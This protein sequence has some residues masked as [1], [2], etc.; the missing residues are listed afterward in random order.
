MKK[1]F[2]FILLITCNA[3]A[4]PDGPP[5]N[6][7][8]VLKELH[9]IKGTR[10]TSLK[11]QLYQIYQTVN[12]A[13][14][15]GSEA[16]DLYLQAEF[17]TQF[18]GESRDK[19]Q[20]I[21][22]KKKQSDKLKSKSFKESLRLYLSYLALTLENSMG[23]KI[24]NLIPSLLNYTTQVSSEIEFLDD[25]NELMK[26]PLDKS[27]IVSYLGVTLTPQANWVN[28]PG[29]LDDI[30]QKVILPEFRLKE[31]PLAIE[32]WNSQIER[33]SEASQY[34]KRLFQADQFATIRK[35]TLFWN[36]A[37]E[38]YLIGQKNRGIT[39]MLAVIKAY[40]THPDASA[41][42]AKLEEYIASIPKVVPTPSL[43]PSPTT[44]P[45]P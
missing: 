10:E 21:D 23:T 9:K 41:W 5:V 3:F 16:M 32:Y 17:S 8:S 34:D 42:A 18:N 31:N 36:K 11:T 33:E 6:P 35:P 39:E 22:W 2:L 25:G 7:E 43:V 26:N 14:L 4:Q 27:L 40:P 28:T 12:A 29:N 20:F 1:L 13:S 15:N 19:I 38:Y 45:L 30:F 24:E 44:A 37:R